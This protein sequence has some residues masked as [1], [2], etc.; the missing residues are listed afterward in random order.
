MTFKEFYIQWYSRVK[1][2][3]CEYVISEEEAEDIAQDIFMELHGNYDSLYDRV[4]MP[5]YV[6]TTVKNRCIDH[7]R[8]KIV[9]RKS[10]D[11]I[12]EEYQLTLQMKFDSLEILDDKI[13]NDENLERKIEEAL[14]NLPEKCR[15]IFIKH[16]IEGVKIKEI[17]E[18]MQ[19][20]PK[21]VE[22]QMTI[23]YR[24]LKDELKE[25]YPLLVFSFFHVYI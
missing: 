14:N 10:I 8:R 18:E 17:A 1:N 24:K 3:A 15:I 5:A 23:A 21:T 12:Q 13:L 11:R 9:N 19:L 25:Y 20:S 22:N 16:K 2:F 6:F 4:N 7:L